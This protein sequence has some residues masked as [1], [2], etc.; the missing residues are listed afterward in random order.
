MHTC[1]EV[2]DHAGVENV[3]GTSSFLE[4]VK[5]AHADH[6]SSIASRGIKEALCE[7]NASLAA[8]SM[9][10]GSAF[11]ISII[12]SVCVVAT[13]ERLCEGGDTR[14][15]SLKPRSTRSPMH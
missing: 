6:S 15:L 10:T 7:K 4:A 12:A 1:V 9:E 5:P 3:R 14:L 11:D 2:D 8:R 13:L